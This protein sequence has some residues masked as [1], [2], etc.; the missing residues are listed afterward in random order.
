MN[1]IFATNNLFIVENILLQKEA[2]IVL[3][4]VTAPTTLGMWLTQK[5]SLTT[6][7]FLWLNKKKKNIYKFV[8]SILDNKHVEASKSIINLKKTRINRQN[9]LLFIFGVQILALIFTLSFIPLI[10]IGL[11][12]FIMGVLLRNRNIIL[13]VL[14][15]LLLASIILPN[16]GMISNIQLKQEFIELFYNIKKFYSLQI[17]WQG[18]FGQQLQ[19]ISNAYLFI[20]SKVGLIGLFIFILGLIQYFKE[21]RNTYLKSDEFE[22]IWIVVILVIFIEFVILAMNSKAFFSWPAGLLFW[23]LY[24]TLQNLKKSKKEYKLIES[25]IGN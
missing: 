20:F 5:N 8:D 13:I 18:T 3:I 17:L 9:L 19:Q 16:I 2:L 10:I 12:I 1:I 7:K 4:M 23:I 14:S 25:V 6:L 21:I 22:R 24:G 11:G 15:L